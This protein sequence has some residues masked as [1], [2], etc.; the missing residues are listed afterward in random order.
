[1]SFPDKI[2]ASNLSGMNTTP[3]PPNRYTYTQLGASQVTFDSDLGRPRSVT[4]DVGLA[5]STSPNGPSTNG[6]IP[7]P[8]VDGIPQPPERN[9]KSKRSDPWCGLSGTAWDL[10]RYFSSNSC[11]LCRQTEGMRGRRLFLDTHI[12]LVDL[13]CLRVNS[14]WVIRF[15]SMT[16]WCGE[17]EEEEEENEDLSGGVSLPYSLLLNL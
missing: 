16:R 17:A 2:V 8:L 1:M 12:R 9:A 10:D 5:T 7:S 11:Q 6:Q 15:V 4:A 13:L 3:D 14:M